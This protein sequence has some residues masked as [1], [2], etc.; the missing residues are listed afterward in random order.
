M[1]KQQ[2]GAGVRRKWEYASI[3]LNKVETQ[4]SFW[5]FRSPFDTLRL[6]LQLTSLSGQPN[7]PDCQTGGD[8]E[9]FLAL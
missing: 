2:K 8:P 4:S 5:H 9:L 6:Q 7:W 3:A 1:S